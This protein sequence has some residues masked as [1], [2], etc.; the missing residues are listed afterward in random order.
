MALALVLDG[1]VKLEPFIDIRPL[2]DLP[3]L[4]AAA[5]RHELRRRVIVSPAAATRKAA[6]QGTQRTTA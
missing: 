6:I 4:F 2:A 1:R 5:S 3:E